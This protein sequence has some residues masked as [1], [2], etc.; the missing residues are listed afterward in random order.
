MTCAHTWTP[1]ELSSNLTTLREQVVW[2]IVEAQHE[3]ATLAIVD[4]IEDQMLLEDILEE[5]KPPMPSDVAGL[6]FLLATPFRYRSVPGA[7]SKD[8]GSRF[9]RAGSLDGVYY[10]AAHP[11]TCAYE[12]AF[13]RALFFNESPG[14]DYPAGGIALSAFST[15]ISSSKVLDLTSHPT[16][17][18]YSAVWED[19]ANY[20]LCQK[21][22]EDARA[23]GVEVIAYK[24]VRDPEGRKNFA[25]LSPNAFASRSIGLQQ[26]WNC[27]LSSSAVFM[28]CEAPA[29]TLAL[30]RADLLKDP[31]FQVASE[32]DENMRRKS[33]PSD[34]I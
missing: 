11:E 28:R 8:S 16:L 3:I 33:S 9:R 15:T 29:K 34:G 22:A 12:T 7:T 23:A 2:R 19:L 31:R 20:E 25:V 21:L 30:Y 32:M 4:S 10:C 17:S 18:A 26:T 14:L 6:P 1:V 13:Y 24:S 5:T 27:L